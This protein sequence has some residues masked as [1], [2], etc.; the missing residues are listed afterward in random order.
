M[1]LLIKSIE[2]SVIIH[3][4]DD[5][6]EIFIKHQDGQHLCLY[7][8]ES[9]EYICELEAE[10]EL[11]VNRLARRQIVSGCSLVARLIPLTV[12][13]C[14]RDVSIHVC[15][16]SCPIAANKYQHC[17]QGQFNL[18]SVNFDCPGISNPSSISVTSAAVCSCQFLGTK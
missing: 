5:K 10:K 6:L 15:Q 11:P 14:T 16:G 2:S 18:L 8:A 13:D 4:D 1:M 12:N 7:N 17:R 3:S 9:K